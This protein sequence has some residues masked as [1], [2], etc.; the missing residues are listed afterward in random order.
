[1]KVR[2]LCFVCIFLVST[3]LSPGL[4]YG[5]SSWAE[6]SFQPILHTNA[7]L[8]FRNPA[9][10]LLF[11]F[12]K[13]GELHTM[14]VFLCMTDL[15]SGTYKIWSLSLPDWVLVRSLGTQEFKPYYVLGS[16]LGPGTKL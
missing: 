14:W 3:N 15:L 7:V 8:H 11:L 2:S 10:I 4:N 13:H 9:L 16:F 12:F 6:S 1:M 5:H